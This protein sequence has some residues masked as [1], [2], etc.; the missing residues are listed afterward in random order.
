MEARRRDGEVEAG[1]LHLGVL[2]RSLDHLERRADIIEGLSEER[3]EIRVGLDGDDRGALCEEPPRDQPRARSD[4]EDPHAAAEPAATFE[5]VVERRRVLRSSRVI[6]RGI[7]PE[8]ATAVFAPKDFLRLR[9]ADHRPSIGVRH[10]V[11]FRLRP[12]CSG[13]DPYLDQPPHLGI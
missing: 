13:R 5:R 6:H 2:E 3:G 7:E 1:V 4:L 9:L 12:R 10:P 11:S 8:K